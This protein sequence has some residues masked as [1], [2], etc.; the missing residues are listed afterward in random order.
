[1]GETVFF[2]PWQLSFSKKLV[3]LTDVIWPMPLN[4]W[5]WEFREEVASDMRSVMKNHYM[6]SVEYSLLHHLKENRSFS[7]QK[8][9]PPEIS[10]KGKQQLASLKDLWS[11]LKLW[12]ALD[13]YKPTR[14]PASKGFLLSGVTGSS[15]CPQSLSHIEMNGEVLVYAGTPLVQ[16][17]TAVADGQALFSFL[18]NLEA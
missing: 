3:H 10:V 14:V 17:V 9:P 16:Q 12:G 15:S 8:N 11:D 5:K 1:M 13:T 2:P 6:K 4:T 7:R 18:G